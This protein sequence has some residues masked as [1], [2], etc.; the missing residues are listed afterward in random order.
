MWWKNVLCVG[1]LVF[2]WLN[3]RRWMIELHVQRK[4][5]HSQHSQVE[6]KKKKIMTHKQT[7]WMGHAKSHQNM[8][9]IPFFSTK[10]KMT[11][12]FLKAAAGKT[13]M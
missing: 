5:Q 8:E 4:H 9:H 11:Q 10:W 13:F 12:V 3:Y 2:I 1:L 7:K 6:K